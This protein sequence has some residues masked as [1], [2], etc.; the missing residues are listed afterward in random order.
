[1]SVL[2]S[3]LYRVHGLFPA[4]Y[5]R[6]LVGQPTGTSLRFANHAADSVRRWADA[7]GSSD[8]EIDKVVLEAEGKIIERVEKLWPILLNNIDKLR[9][10]DFIMVA[11][12][13][14]G[15]PVAIM[16]IAKLIE[17][18]VISTSR[19]GFCAMG[20]SFLVLTVREF[21]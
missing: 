13:S 3:D 21:P 7:N 19:I 20:K 11:S 10:A 8:V 4:T 18:G 12:H 9:K 15:V 2:T 16:L 5:L 17:F 14:Q 6:K 1:M